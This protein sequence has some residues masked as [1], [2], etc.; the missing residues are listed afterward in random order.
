MS[1][2]SRSGSRSGPGPDAMMKSE[3]VTGWDQF[4]AE[5]EEMR[6]T[7]TKVLVMES[8]SVWRYPVQT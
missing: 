5:E 4:P 8:W 3:N 2:K 7:A 1:Q 6:V